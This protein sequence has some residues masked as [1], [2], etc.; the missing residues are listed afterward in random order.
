MRVR[1]KLVG[2]GQRRLAP[3]KIARRYERRVSKSFVTRQD[4][5]VHHGRCELD[6]HADT[7]VAGR[8]CTVLHYTERICD[9]MP[10]SDDYEAKTGISIV[11]AATG[12]T[13]A[14]GQRYI[15]VFNEALWM[16][17]RENSLMN[18]NQ[19]RHFG[20]EVQDNPYDQNPMLIRKESDTD[21][22]VACLKSR[23]TDIFID[24][25]TP[26][27]QDLRENVHV[28]L[29]SLTQWDPHS[30]RF[31]QTSKSEIDE[32]EGYNISSINTATQRDE[33]DYGDSY[34]ETLRV[35]DINTFNARIMK[36]SVIPTLVST[37]KISE[38]TLLPPKTFL[39]S[40]QHSNTT[41]ED[42]SEVWNISVEQAKMTLEATTQHHARSA[43]MP[44]SR[45]YRI[46][47]MFEPTRLRS[48]MASD[49]MDP[50]CAGL[51][52]DRYCQVFGN[53]QMF[54]EA[55]P[56]GKKSDCD[57]ALRRFLQE[58]GAPDEM[59]TDGSREQTA[60]GSK[61][62]ST[63][64]KN[65]TFVLTANAPQVSIGEPFFYSSPHRGRNG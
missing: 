45:R 4:S 14:N 38:D 52:G 47:R 65:R 46:D 43:I 59:I 10:Y 27:D 16:P 11:Q 25:W 21:G 54:A 19:L 18:P 24:T 30:I 53:K 63:L 33:T 55:Y 26:T 49:T 2:H 34:H 39:S 51:H 60:K 7:F 32:I 37:G 35:F 48:S 58:Y 6:S 57:D 42:L 44:L 36:S 31:P 61:F 8:N 13:A 22:F 20:I 17:E 64:R 15:L 28:V 62:Q 41:P 5:T 1:G 29:T 50:R 56:I 23:G 9:V 3:I 12:Y 40:K